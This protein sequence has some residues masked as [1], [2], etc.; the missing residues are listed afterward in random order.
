M[1]LEKQFGNP[2]FTLQIYYLLRYSQDYDCHIKI[3]KR[4]IKIIKLLIFQIFENISS[5]FDVYEAIISSLFL[6][7]LFMY[8][9]LANKL[10]QQIMDHNN[11]IFTTV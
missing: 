1:F 5:R 8:M 2:F 11:H 4:E 3:I 10:A 9:F 7:I 6:V